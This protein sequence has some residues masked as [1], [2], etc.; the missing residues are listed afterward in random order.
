MNGVVKAPTLTS[1]LREIVGTA[2]VVD[3][4][5]ASA[6]LVGARYGEGAALCVVRPASAREVSA[7]VALCARQ[8]IQVVAQGA[9][10]GLVG[11]STPDASGT[12]VV[13]SL[14]RLRETCAIDPS[15]RTAEVDAGFLLH[16]LNERLEAHGLWFPVDLAADPTIGGMIATNTGG[17]KLIRYGDVRHN[18]L[19]AE[20]VLFDPPGEIIKLGKPLRKNNS[21]FDLK[22]LFVGSAGATGIVTRATLELAPRPKQTASALLVPSSDEKVVEILLAAETELGEFLSAFEGM[23]GSSINAALQHS[24]SLRSPFGDTEVPDFAVLIEL[25]TCLPPGQGVELDS[26]LLKFLEAH[27]GNGVSDAVLGRGDDLWRLR[28]SLSEGAR[29]LG[30]VIGIDVAVKRSE[31]MRF[32]REA[33]KL[34]RTEYPYLIPVDFGHV[35][36]GGIHFNVVWPRHS[37]Q[38]FTAAVADD[39]RTRLHQLVVD[40]FGGSFSA[41]HGVGPHN[42]RS[43]LKHTPAPELRLAGKIQHTLD[44]RALGGGM[45][46]GPAD[47]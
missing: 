21:G 1:Q 26:L 12:Q 34:I 42:L 23:S 41:E 38:S 2:G 24:H 37:T 13:V 33:Y 36:D 19:A 3:G 10:T 27:F 45:R 46:Y 31:V 15:N 16:E 39:V 17:T 30:Q 43:Y 11:A 22:H 29:S 35:G 32:R 28:H 7:I 4:T 14:T 18:V 20:A 47:S 8:N 40:A 5:E 9:N 44:P 6:F 25:T